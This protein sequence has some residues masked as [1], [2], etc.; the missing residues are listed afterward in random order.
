[1]MMNREFLSSYFVLS[2][3]CVMTKGYRRTLIQDFVRNY[4]DF[5]PNEYYELCMSLDRHQI[6][7][8]MEKVDEKSHAYFFEFVDFMLKKEYAFLTEKV[9]LFP[10]IST[11]LH[12]QSQQITDA[13]IEIDEK[14]SDMNTVKKFLGELASVKCRDIQIRLFSFSGFSSLK[15]LAELIQHYEL[16]Y[17]EI[18]IDNS[19]VLA[20]EECCNILSGHAQISNIFLYDA[21]KSYA[22]D[23]YERGEGNVDIQLGSVIYIEDKLDSNKCGIV[24]KYCQVYGNRRF[25]LMS[26]DY[27]SCLFKKVSLDKNG[28]VRNCPSLPETYDLSLGLGNI[29]KSQNFR[30][31]WEIKKDEIEVCKDCEFRYNCLDCR[32]HTIKGNIYSKPVSCKYNPYQ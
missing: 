17:V 20:Y 1:M 22:K 9:S 24:N 21:P 26:K 6:F 32:A 27:N 31:Y 19:S 7:E 10:P 25:Y 23:Y 13:I 3:S 16:N 15:K 5:I 18:H 12:E 30:K 11:K 28:M 8:I 29:V 14:Y 2:S 4:A